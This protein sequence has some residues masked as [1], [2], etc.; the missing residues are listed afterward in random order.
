MRLEAQFLILFVVC[1]GV[2]LLLAGGLSYRVESDHA[3]HE[4]AATAEL[5]LETADALKAY[6]TEEIAPSLAGSAE[7][8]QRPSLPSYEATQVLTRLGGRLPHFSYREVALEPI[9]ARNRAT[10]QEVSILRQFL[11]QPD[12]REVSGVFFEPAPARYYLARPVYADG[13]GCSAC[14]GQDEL[15]TQESSV[16][17]HSRQDLKWKTGDLIA[18]QI[19]KIPLQT[20]WK[21][22]VSSIVITSA[23]LASVFLITGLAFLLL[24]RRS[25]T[26][27]LETL[28]LEAEQLSLDLEESAPPP[29]AKISGSFARLDRALRRLQVSMRHS[30]DMARGGSSER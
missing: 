20:A 19:V 18:A 21:T 10:H 1:L 3:R 24:F 7:A 6:T 23:G 26:R 22:S 15:S 5:V 25:I 11:N 28:T 12:R 29:R 14:H 9:D 30:L 8:V 4:L 27:P 17:Y 16:P 13:P 2:G